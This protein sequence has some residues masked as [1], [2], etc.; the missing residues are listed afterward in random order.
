MKDDCH[1][2]ELRLEIDR[3]RLDDEWSNQP[4]QY[5]V[6]A[7]K[8]AEAQLEFDGLKSDQSLTFAELDKEIRDN[9]EEYGVSKL[10]ESVVDSTVRLQ[11]EF[12]A[13]S[14]AL[15][16]ARYKL[17]VAEAAVQAL[18]HRKRALTMLVELWIHEYYADPSF[19]PLT[20]G[21]EEFQKH[22]I[23]SRGGRRVASKQEDSDRMEA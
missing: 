23:R 10:T 1:Q 16:K 5:Y 3:L 2:Q 6:W 19:K 4:S 17:S 11:K 9:P 18:E 13:S 7:K 15:N 12:I 14:A 20:E 21:G 8:V 22:M